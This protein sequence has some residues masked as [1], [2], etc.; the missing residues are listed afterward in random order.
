MVLSAC[1]R[2]GLEPS[3]VALIGDIGADMGA[4]AAAGARSVLVPT[5]ITLEEEV[6]A[7]PAVARDLAGA[8][9]LLGVGAS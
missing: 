8:V 7:A 3:E 9:R 4:A 5:D 2:L 6:L 1:A